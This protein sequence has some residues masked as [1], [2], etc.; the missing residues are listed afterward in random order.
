KTER[1]PGSRAPGTRLAGGGEEARRTAG[2]EP[3]RGGCTAVPAIAGRSGHGGSRQSDVAARSLIRSR[4]VAARLF[5]RAIDPAEGDFPADDGEAVEEAGAR[6]DTGR[7]DAHGVDDL[8]E[9]EAA[10]GEV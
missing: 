2:L 1:P 5:E 4:R 10:L 8:T 3:R 9:G 7:G 6:G